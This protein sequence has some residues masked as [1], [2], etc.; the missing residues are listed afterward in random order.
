MRVIIPVSIL[1]VAV[2][3]LAFVTGAVYYIDETQQVVIT[4][5]GDPIGAPITDA[6]LH[7]KTPL[8]RQANYFE[9][10][11]LEWDGNPNQIPTKDKKY[12]WVD[13]T[14]RWRIVD[15]L[16]FLQSVGNENGAYA[17]LDDIIDSATRNFI[18]NNNLVEAVRDSNRILEM[19]DYDD[20]TGTVEQTVREIEKIEI[21]R[22]TLTRGIL[23]EASDIVVQYGI[24]LID[25]RIKRINY[26]AEV[27]KKVF[28]RMISERKRAAEQ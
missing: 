28:E 25:V 3:V 5:F 1:I 19:T 6:G 4:Q 18:T 7:F 17:R 23:E 13:T 15:A 11:I 16:K 10:R 14:A 9:K 12:I 26:V 22:D 2:I 21:G 20:E 24:K 27:Q 8:I